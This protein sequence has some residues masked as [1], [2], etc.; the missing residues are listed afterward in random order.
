MAGK[1]IELKAAAEKLGI[2]QERLLEMRD[3]GELHGYRDGS[4]WKFKI[5]DITALSGRLS[6]GAD[7]PADDIAGLWEDD[8][9]ASLLDVSDAS[10][11]AE[12]SSITV[13]SKPGGEG[14]STAIGKEDSGLDLDD[15]DLQL[16]NLDDGGSGKSDNGLSDFDLTLDEKEEAGDDLAAVDDLDF[17][18]DDALALHDDDEL[19]LAD[20]EAALDQSSGS[21]VKVGGSDSDSDFDS[22]LLLGDDSL[23]SSDA[24]GLPEDDDMVSLDD[25]L[26]ASPDD[27]AKLQ[28]DE[29]FLL[30]PSGE[31]FGDESSDSGSQVIALDDSSAFVE[32]S[33]IVE[34][35]ES[36]E[37]ILVPDDSAG[38]EGLVLAGKDETMAVPVGGPAGGGMM[39]ETPYSVWNLMGL[40]LVVMMLSITGMLMAD[41][42]RNMW[43][44]NGEPVSGGVANAIIE[45]LG[46][47]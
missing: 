16:A 33:D 10:G 42:V 39:L 44:W 38:M 1:F 2:T 6:S 28:P 46:I 35:V 18:S 43:S 19:D 12:D 25:A 23:G 9:L 4:S 26:A 13:D 47:K 5:E 3:A 31:M 37:P 34:E 11:E 22:D 14:S 40:L 32:S 7:K 30:S 15:D 21:E 20:D 29:E 8:D 17:D 24:L 27:A 45:A 36:D 41:I